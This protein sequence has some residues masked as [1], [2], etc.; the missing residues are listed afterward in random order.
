MVSQGRKDKIPEFRAAK[1]TAIS[2]E[3][4]RKERPRKMSLKS[5]CE[6]CTESQLLRITYARQD[7]GRPSKERWRAGQRFQ[8]QHR[9]ER[10]EVGI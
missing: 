1:T 6:N 4:S 9:L 7:F 5:L 10:I 3:D 8:R 2:G